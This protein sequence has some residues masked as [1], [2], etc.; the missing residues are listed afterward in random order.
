[1]KKPFLAFIVFLTLGLFQV[2]E[3]IAVEVNTP[4]ATILTDSILKVKINSSESVQNLQSHIETL[5]TKIEMQNEKIEYLIHLYNQLGVFDKLSEFK[6]E[7]SEKRYLNDLINYVEK[8]YE[9]E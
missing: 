3:S 9:A 8:K 4:K 2:S 5:E 7:P 1:M 6:I